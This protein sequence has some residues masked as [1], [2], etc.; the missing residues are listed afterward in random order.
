M[1]PPNPEE[2]NCSSLL[3]RACMRIRNFSVTIVE[4]GLSQVKKDVLWRLCWISEQ[5]L[6]RM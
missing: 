2:E 6:N 3:S 4:W 1:L 5:K